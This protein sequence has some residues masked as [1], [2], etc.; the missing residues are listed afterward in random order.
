MLWPARGPISTYFGFVGPLSPRGQAGIDIAAPM[1]APVLAAQSG[2]VDLA[3]RDGGYGIYVVIDHGGG[4]RT[5]YAHLSQLLV[6][7][8]QSVGRGEQIGLVGSTGFSTGP[9]LHFEVRQ[10]GALR[11]PLALLP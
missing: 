9:H 1:G 4:V 11:D 3:T 10:N 6:S 8:G 5:L 2:V 7:P